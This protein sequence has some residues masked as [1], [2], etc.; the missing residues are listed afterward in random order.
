M[1]HA[2]GS[3]SAAHGSGKV[4]EYLCVGTSFVG[5]RFDL[6]PDGGKSAVLILVFL[7]WFR[8]PDESQKRLAQKGRNGVSLEYYFG[9][10]LAD[11]LW[12]LL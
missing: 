10:M 8:K 6:R 5:F 12:R 2:S 7:L 9:D 1:G 11:K 3:R 4:E